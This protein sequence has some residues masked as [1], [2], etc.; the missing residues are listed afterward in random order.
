MSLV[1]T[2]DPIVDTERRFEGF[3]NL[4]PFRVQEILLVGKS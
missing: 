2:P 3:E 4:L 1:H